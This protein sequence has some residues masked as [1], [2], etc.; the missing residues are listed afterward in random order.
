MSYDWN[1][2]KCAKT[3]SNLSTYLWLQDLTSKCYMAWKGAFDVCRSVT[4]HS[5]R[6]PRKESAAMP[7]NML[8]YNIAS[9]LL[10]TLFWWKDVSLAFDEFL[11]V[12]FLLVFFRHLDCR[13]WEEK[14]PTSNFVDSVQTMA[15]LF[16]TVRAQ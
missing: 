15:W 5:R 6:L 11:Q 14:W 1:Q 7:P 13:H 12:I 2:S 9:K 10:S 8:L 16:Y 4:R 3:N